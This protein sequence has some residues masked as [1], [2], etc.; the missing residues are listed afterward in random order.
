MPVVQVQMGNLKFCILASETTL[1]TTKN[2]YLSIHDQFRSLNM[3][4]TVDNLNNNNLRGPIQPSSSP[5][6]IKDKDP[7]LAFFLLLLERTQFRTLAP[8][9]YSTDYS[10]KMKCSWIITIE[11]DYLINSMFIVCDIHDD[12]QF[13]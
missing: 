2:N 10:N 13:R 3:G 8:P 4:N 12:K 6:T 5:A 7:C 11:N 9:K 1:L